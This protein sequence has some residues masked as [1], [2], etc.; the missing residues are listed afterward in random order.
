MNFRPTEETSTLPDA[1]QQQLN[2][3]VAAIT[4]HRCQSLP[5]YLTD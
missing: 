4:G 2:K 1:D 5:F 3:L